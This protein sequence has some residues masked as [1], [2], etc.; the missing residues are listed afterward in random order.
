MLAMLHMR[1]GWG[2]GLLFIHDGETKSFKLLGVLFDEYLS[3]DDHINNL[4]T[5]ISKSLFCKNRIKS[6]VNP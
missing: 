4:C 1:G 3:F 6:F 5:K 2:G